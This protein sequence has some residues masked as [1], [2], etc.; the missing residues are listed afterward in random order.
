VFDND[1]ERTVASVAEVSKKDAETLRRAAAARSANA[2]NARVATYFR[3]LDEMTGFAAANE[4]WESPQMRAAS[5][6][7]G[8][9]FGPIGS[10]YGTGLQAFSMLDHMKGR[11]VPKGGSGML[12]QALG[13]FIEAHDGAILT[14]KPVVQLIIEGGKCAGVECADG[15][16]YRAER[17]VVSTIHVKHLIE[18]APRELFGADILDTVDLMQPEIAMFQFHFA[19]SEPPK[20]PLATGGTIFSNEASVME[21]ATS[22][23]QLGIDN[24]KGELNIADY[25]LQVCHPAVFDKTRV[26]DGYGLLKIE[27]CL[28]YGLKQ[29]RDHWD[30]IKDEIAGQV[31]DRYMRHTANLDK[32]KLL[33]KFLLSP[34][35][36]E[37]MNPSMWL[38]GVHAFDNRGGNFA[39]YRMGIPGL[40]QTGACTA[41]GGSI[42]GIPGRNAAEVVLQD[43][44]LT[45]EQVVANRGSNSP[46]K[47]SLL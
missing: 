45:I 11:P 25:P 5:L 26:P 44:G 47:P 20:Y 8:R 4:V 6:S 46:H 36:I 27:G 35:D 42:S 33:A 41:P 40:Y 14:S 30:V 10:D 2:P 37:R 38:G 19:F 32:T 12:T 13:R 3:R 31:L 29:G 7:G 18:M 9:F 39:P 23:F 21:D 16:Q 28:P 1:L 22:I 34:V 43:Q 17:G 24:A 15:T